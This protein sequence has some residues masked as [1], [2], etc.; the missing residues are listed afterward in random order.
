MLIRDGDLQHIQD[1]TQYNEIAEE[2]ARRTYDQ[3]GDFY[4]KPFSIHARESLDDHKGNNGIFTKDQLT[5]NSNIPSP[6]LGTYKIS[7]GK[8]F[9]RGFEVDS[10]TVHYLDFEKTRSI[11]TLKEQAVNY[12]TGPTLT[13]NRTF[14][15]PRI[16]FST[17]STISLR[18]SR[19][20]VTSTTAAGKEIGI[21]R[22]YDYALE[23]G[24]YSSVASDVNEWDITLYDIQPYLRLIREALHD[25]NLD[26]YKL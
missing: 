14:G 5:Y 11:K 18:D 15:A 20:G 26:Y 9:I 3:S 4:V 1:R 13:L 24:S 16:G 23:S 10:G 7:P 21:A 12:F 22:V 25:Y 6:D 17:S 2:L 8:A 19:I